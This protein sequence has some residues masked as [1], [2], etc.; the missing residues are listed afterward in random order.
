MSGVSSP[1]VLAAYD[2]VRSDK[3]ETNWLLIT[4]AGNMGNKLE[5]SATGTG[6]IT[7]LASRLDNTQVA[8]AYV[9]VE[10]A[11]DAESKRIKFYMVVWRGSGIKPKRKF[12]MNQ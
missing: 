11:N 4:Y 2:A 9:R 5:L 10:Y 8:Y 12:R 7:E 1:E 6:G 3:E